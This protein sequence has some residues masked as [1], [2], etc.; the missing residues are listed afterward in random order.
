MVVEGV[1]TRRQVHRR[2]RRAELGVEMPITEAR[3]HAV[4]FDGVASRDAI[5][6]LMDRT[7]KPDVNG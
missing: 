4:L 2:P 5:R 3:S 7:P 6:E 1:P